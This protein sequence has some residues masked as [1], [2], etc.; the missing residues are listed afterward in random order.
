MH[1]IS[2]GLLGVAVG[3]ILAGPALSQEE[4]VLNIYNWSDYIA[5]DTIS[6]FETATGIKVRY[7]VFDSNEVLEAKLLAGIPVTTWSS[8]HHLS[9][10]ARSRLAYS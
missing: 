3:T 8:R 4:K 6:N 9:W 7:D 2:R 1:L 5:E 10:P